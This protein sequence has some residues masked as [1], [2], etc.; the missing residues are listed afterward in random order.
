METKESKIKELMKGMLI[1]TI[2]NCSLLALLLYNVSDIAESL[3]VNIIC[4]FKMVFL[5]RENF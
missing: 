2:F 1:G 3:I 5:Y 4:D